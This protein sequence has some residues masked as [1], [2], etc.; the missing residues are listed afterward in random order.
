MANDKNIKI[1]TATDIEKYHRGLLSSKEMHDMEKAALD[2][3]FLADA[4]EGYAAN[5]DSAKDIEE[6]QQ[7]LSERT[8][9]KVVLLHK[10][11]PSSY[12]WLRVA[13]M[14][15]L[16]AGAG[17]F[18]YQLN[19][20]SDNKV[21]KLN[22][23]E[24]AAL[25]DSSSF[26]TAS[27]SPLLKTDSS[28]TIQK[29]TFSNGLISDKSDKKN[30]V[31]S[32]TLNLVTDSTAAN[33]SFIATAPANGETEKR[34]DVVPA[35]K[36]SYKSSEIAARRK[37]E[38]LKTNNE[39]SVANPKTITGYTTNS[40]NKDQLFKDNYFRGR[41]I[42]ANNNP[43]PFANITNIED[44]AG[45]YTDA[46]GNF[47]LVSPDSI[48]NI[49]IRSIGFESNI[50]QL[51]NNVANNQVVMQ[52]DHKTLNETVMSNVKPNAAARAGINTMKLEEPEP[53]DGW[54][55]YDAYLVNN[56]NIPDEIKSKQS[57]S[58]VVEISFEVNSQG[59]PINIKIEKSLCDLCDK[60]AIRLVKEG[61]KWK[62]K[63]KKGRTTVTIP[64]NINQ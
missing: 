45:T 51:K 32:K 2:D 10:S 24:N 55:N 16:L 30:V 4:L 39:P 40:H 57:V 31:I 47:I 60:E 11:K 6:L 22:E 18:I 35:E 53:E 17:Y 41:V 43:V 12:K 21:A 50:T 5:I 33:S 42:D 38:S 36:D 34:S 9:A 14:I 56:L 61:P 23:K 28:K 52:Y 19:S 48:L 63:A 26:V 46:K 58:N 59:E 54:A 1:Y 15:I 27:N 3:P 62:R 13:A 49:Q 29:S 64:F 44:T 25:K 8:L 20:G 37:E 7:K